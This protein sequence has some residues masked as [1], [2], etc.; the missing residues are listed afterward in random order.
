MKTRR[1]VV[2]ISL[3]TYINSAS[4]AKE[5]FQQI[6]LHSGKEDGVEQF[7]FPSLGT[8]YP[9]A[10]IAKDSQIGIGAQNISPVFNGPYTG[11]VSIESVIEAG[12]TY[13][14]I[15]HAERKR[16]FHED[17]SMIN[18]KVKLTLDM[19]LTPVLCIGEEI[20]A[21]SV[22]NLKVVLLDQLKQSLQEIEGNVVSKIILAYEPVWAIGQV[23]A[24]DAE[25]VHQAHR[26]IR[27]ILTELFGSA[28]A[29]DVRLIYGGAISKDNTK[30]I[31]S[32]EN[33][34]GVFVGRFGHDPENYKAIVQ[35]V[36]DTKVE[37][38]VTSIANPRKTISNE[39]RDPF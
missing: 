2:G 13:V 1:P 8:L 21:T 31:I 4:K 18:Q 11:E 27:D 38:L 14:E 36:K 30:E 35:I 16:L 6:N 32:N 15:G 34:D 5:F 17:L 7:L 39:K 28:I 9:V 19:G 26:V 12:A 23:K 25:Y 24:A 3:K 20:M 29:K 10:E 33:V 37:A 22:S